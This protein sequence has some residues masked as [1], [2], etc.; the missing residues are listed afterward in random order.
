M[1]TCLLEKLASIDTPILT[2]NEKDYDFLVKMKEYY[3]F[4]YDVYSNKLFM[5]MNSYYKFN[6]EDGITYDK[7]INKCIFLIDSLE[8]LKLSL[9]EF[10]NLRDKEN[11]I[12]LIDKKTKERIFCSFY[13]EDIFSFYSDDYYFVTFKDSKIKNLFEKSI[14]MH[15]SKVNFDV[16]NN[17]DKIYELEEKELFKL[18]PNY[19]LIKINKYY[20]GIFIL[21]YYKFNG[22]I[23]VNVINKRNFTKDEILK[24]LLKFDD[25][26]I[27]FI[28]YNN[29]NEIIDYLYFYNIM[30]ELVQNAREK[31][32]YIKFLDIKINK[33]NNL[34]KKD[35]HYIRL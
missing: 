23:F 7:K 31:Y 22:F 11:L 25:L 35:E 4:K 28:V 13:E 9:D 6:Y 27:G 21:S 12:I 29:D 30:N 26:M 19:E 32:I 18:L 5:L 3:N 34:L 16:I 17:Q 33:V 14:M 8:E 10:L 15:S 2:D 24:I 1:E 20:E